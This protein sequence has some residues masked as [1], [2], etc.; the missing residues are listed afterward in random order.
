MDAVLKEQQAEYDATLAKAKSAWEE[1]KERRRKA[2]DLELLQ[3][4]EETLRAE[5]ETDANPNDPLSWLRMAEAMDAA[6]RH[7]EAERCRKTAMLLMK[8][9]TL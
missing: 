8:K 4:T 9:K 2:K 1:E 5:G 3:R 7:E 6:K